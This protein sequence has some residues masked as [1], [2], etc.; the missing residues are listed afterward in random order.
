VEAR[1]KAR[2]SAQEA[3]AASPASPIQEALEG[4]VG[5]SVTERRERYDEAMAALRQRLR[6]DTPWCWRELRAVETVV[7]EVAQ[8]FN[9]EDPLLPPV[10]NVLDKAHQELADLPEL[11]V[12]VGVEVE[13]S[14][15]DEERVA[16]LRERLLRAPSE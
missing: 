12:A 9:G 6:E 15:P 10:R 2:L 5:R 14:E 11:L 8:E 1:R 3:I 13:L 4:A 16:D 7:E